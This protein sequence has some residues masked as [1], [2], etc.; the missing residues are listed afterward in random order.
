MHS[1]LV[2]W[3]ARKGVLTA[4]QV[5]Q[6]L[7]LG[8]LGLQNSEDISTLFQPRRPWYSA[9]AAGADY[10][11]HDMHQA[12]KHDTNYDFFANSATS[13]EVIR[14]NVGFGMHIY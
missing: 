13:T 4:P 11:T 9:T 14:N 8:L 12:L 1:E 2:A 3:V 7:G 6:H 10:D 5:C